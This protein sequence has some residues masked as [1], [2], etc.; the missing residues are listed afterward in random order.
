ML[1]ELRNSMKG[2]KIERITFLKFL[3]AIIFF[4][5]IFGLIVWQVYHQ[6]VTQFLNIDFSKKSA[7]AVI[8]T[9]PEIIESDEL[10]VEDVEWIGFSDKNFGLNF[11]YPE[12]F[13]FFDL[14]INENGNQELRSQEFNLS[15][16]KIF[17]EDDL[18]SFLVEKC[19]LAEGEELLQ[20]KRLFPSYELCQFTIL[21]K[22][23]LKICNFNLEFKEQSRVVL[24]SFIQASNFIF[25]F[26]TFYKDNSPEGKNVKNDFGRIL[27][28]V[29]FIR[30]EESETWID[31]KNEKLGFS[32]NYLETWTVQEEKKLKRIYFVSDKEFFSQDKLPDAK[33]I[34]FSYD[35][36]EIIDKEKYLGSKQVNVKEKK[37]I[38]LTDNFSVY[39]YDYIDIDLGRMASVFW[40]IGDYRF[41]AQT[42]PS[43]DMAIQEYQIKILLKMMDQ[44][45][46]IKE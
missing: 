17:Y 12:Y 26:D 39:F 2:Y 45:K 27:D 43:A 42:V 46:I 44:L 29:D 23:K 18:N 13:G 14:I 37:E 9:T 33:V 21:E 11:E 34:W 20:C 6:G 24:R 40:R 19:E 16:E 22:S 36:S 1:N 35:N 25:I 4:I 30:Q 5:I 32:L 8:E 28:S 7:V 3:L 10:K 15:I 38:E 41:L 31:Y